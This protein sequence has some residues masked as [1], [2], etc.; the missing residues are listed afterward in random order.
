MPGIL[1]VAAVQMDARPAATMER[2]ARADRLVRDAAQAGAEL[3]VLPELFNTG[4]TFADSNFANAE[5]FDGPTV[6]WL[7]TTAATL[8]IHLAGSL[9]LRERRDIDNALLLFA[10]DGRTWRYDKRYPWGW[11][12][13]YYRPARKSVIAETSLGNIGMLICWDSAHRNVWSALA[14]KVDL[15]L[16]S[17]CPPNVSNP[18]Y[19]FPNGA[20]MTFDDLGP[21]FGL[22]KGS[23]ERVFGQMINTQAAW[24]GVPLV[25]SIG[26]GKI[27]TAIP[28]GFASLLAFLPLAPH[29]VRHLPYAR[30]M[31]MSCAMTPGCK[32]VSS[33]GSVLAE[34][35][36]EAGDT[37]AISTVSLADRRPRPH[38][39]QPRAPVSWITYLASDIV[40]PWLSIAVYRRGTRKR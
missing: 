35:A 8:N 20:Q 9:L 24:L 39:A 14:G 40:L 15:V 5:S 12:R 7:R 26:A 28:N 22:M 3:V 29:V 34:A 16:I 17:S 11:E 19:H 13:G 18:T 37:F 10:P 25:N 27:T 6:S 38:A 21:L 23:A 30:H 36:P 1:T 2:L 4:Y 32:I 33:T 31:Q